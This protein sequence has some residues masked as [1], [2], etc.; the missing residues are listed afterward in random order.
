[1]SIGPDNA[2][3]S[4]RCKQRSTQQAL[5]DCCAQLVYLALTRAM[6]MHASALL[7]PWMVRQA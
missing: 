2:G 7:S 4:W 6:A 3:Q 1:M 5:T